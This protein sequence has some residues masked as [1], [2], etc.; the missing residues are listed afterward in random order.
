MG[1]RI[2]AFSLPTVMVVSVLISLLVLFAMSLANLENQAYHVYHA[3]KQNILDLHSAV[4]RYCVDSVMFYGRE[5][6]VSVRLFET[7]SSPVILAKKDWGLFEVVTA[8]SE[9]LPFSYTVLCGKSRETELDAALWI[10]DKHRPLSLSGDTRIDGPVYIPQSGINYTEFSGRSFAGNPVEYSNMGISSA[11]LPA[12]D[13]SSLSS[14]LRYRD[15]MSRAW[16]FMNSPHE[17]VSHSDSTVFVYGKNSDHV[18]QLGGNQVLFGDRLTISA[19]S[20]LDGILIVA[21]TITL[22]DGFRGSGQF[23]CTDSLLI[24]NHVHL[25][26]PSGVFASGHEHPYISIGRQ[27]QIDGYVVVLNEGKEDKDLRY[28]CLL[29]Q[30]NSQISG[31]VYVDGAAILEGKIYGSTFLGDCYTQVDGRKYPGV[32]KDVQ[33]TY[34]ANVTYPKLLNGPYRRREIRKTY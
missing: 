24:G 15:C 31:L 29:Q 21:R 5:D 12:I 30:K 33:F 18:Y 26:A 19:G 9:Y 13:S 25:S 27:S 14:I 34:D 28:P 7:S 1:K 6:T 8:R 10:C 22:E 16:Y 23:I 32:L 20:W 2:K 11:T 4:E 17:Y 3:R